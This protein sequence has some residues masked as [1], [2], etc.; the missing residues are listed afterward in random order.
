[1]TPEQI[2]ANPARVLSQAQREHYFDGQLRLRATATATEELSEGL[3]FPVRFEVF[4]GHD[5]LTQRVSYRKLQL[6]P[7][8]DE[9][10]FAFEPEPATGS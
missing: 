6:N 2:L 10:L 7:K 9:D 8:L 3:F 5:A 4:D 1:M